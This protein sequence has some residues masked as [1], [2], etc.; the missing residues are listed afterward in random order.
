MQI[1]IK[2][3]NNKQIS[4]NSINMKINKYLMLIYI[5]IF[6]L[7][8][9]KQKPVNINEDADARSQIISSEEINNKIKTG[10]NILYK[11]ATI[12]GDVDFLISNDKNFMTPQ[13][14][15]HYINSS[16]TFY[17]CTFKGKISA[18]K[19]FTNHY[20]ICLFRKNITFI[21]CT[22][23]DSVNFSSSEFQDLVNFNESVFQNFTSFKA[24][25]FNYNKNY[26][27]NTHFIKNAEFNM[28]HVN[29]NI[30]FF[31]S[32]F[33]A[34]VI[35]QLTKFMFQVQFGASVFHDNVDFSN[36][37]FYDDLLFNYAE[38]VKSVN[39]NGS[40]FNGRTEFIQTKFNY[41]S[42]F[43]NCF[44]YGKINFDKSDAKGIIKFLNNY[45]S[46]N[47]PERKDFVLH[48]GTDFMN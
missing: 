29:G 28:M 11:N 5:P 43:T 1:V 15:K 47:K 46:I 36:I 35:F 39:F 44:F 33:D 13:L 42:E 6:F 2:Q 37:K 30:S 19:S 23:Q 18:Y 10:E 8:C 45:Y 17:N 40:I 31:K 32:E 41:I 25:V 16:I 27:E 22:F 34:K 4:I 38:F 26:F 9:Q 48:E 24:T 12:T 14:I 20:E 21:N 3:S 7:S